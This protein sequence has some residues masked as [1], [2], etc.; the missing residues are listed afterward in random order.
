MK[1]GILKRSLLFSVVVLALAA[2]TYSPVL[3]QDDPATL[4]IEVKPCFQCPTGTTQEDGTFIC[5]DGDEDGFADWISCGIPAINLCSKGKTAVAILDF[6][7]SGIVPA[8]ATITFGGATSIRCSA[9]DVDHDVAEGGEPDDL[10]CH[11][12]TRDLVE[13]RAQADRNRVQVN[14]CLTVTQGETES[15]GCDD[16]VIFMRG[17]CKGL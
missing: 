3:A 13:L 7:D 11:F 5:P 15:T 2:L 1:K 10:V 8:D 17:R 9:R 4:T 6:A 14:A 12:L 16:V